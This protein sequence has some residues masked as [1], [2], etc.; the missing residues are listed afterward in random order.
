MKNLVLLGEI[1]RKLNSTSPVSESGDIVSLCEVSP[2]NFE[3]ETSTVVLTENG[4]VTR[5]TEEGDSLWTCNLEEV[6]DVGGGWFD[7]SFIDPELVCL[8]K[9]GAIVTVD[10]TTG[11]AELVGV[12]DQGLE[13][14]AWSPDK[15]ILLMVTSIEDD[16]DE[17]GGESKDPEINSHLMTMNASFEVL[18]EVRIPNY[19]PSSTSSD[20]SISVAWRPDGSLCAVSSVDAEDS[21]RNVRIYKRETLEV[22]AIGRAEDA[23][24]ALVKNLQNASIAWASTGCSQLLASV[25]RKGKK[26]QQVVFF[27]PNGLRHREFVLREQA[28]TVVSTL[29]WNATSDIL[30]V[31]LREEDGSDKIQLWHRCNYHWYL[32]QELRF[33]D[34]RIQRMKFSKENPNELLVILCGLE[35]RMYEVRW[36]PSSVLSFQEKSLAFVVDGSSLN[37]TAFQKALIPPPMFANNCGMEFPIN[38][39]TFC[40]ANQ[41]LGST[42]VQ[43]SNG[44][45]ILLQHTKGTASSYSQMKVLWG[46]KNEIDELSLRSLLI[47][48]AEED[49]LHVVAFQSGACNARKDK[50][51]EIT[52][53]NINT[54]EPRSDIIGSQ[55]LEGR[56]QRA[57]QWSD[58]IDGCIIQLFDGSLFEYE[59]SRPTR[60][61]ASELEPMLELCPWISAIK[62]V[63]PYSDPSH[64]DYNRSR[65]VF[66]LSSKSRLYFNDVMLAD[67]ASSFFLSLNHEFLCYVTTGSRCQ[68]RFL[69]LKEVHAFD[70]LMGPE[71]H[72]VLEGYEP[73][74][75]EQGSRVVAI[76][77]QQPQMILQMPRGNLESIYP[78]ALVLQ[79]LMA[80][81]TAGAYGEAFRMMRKHKVDLNLIVDL[82][83]T[84][85]LESGITS[86][87]KQV[88]N[89][90][91]LNL[92][93]S[94][95]QNYD[96]TQARFPVPTWIQS[97]NE[98]KKG[99]E[100]FDFS[101]KVNSICRKARSV[102][103]DIEKAGEKPSTYYLLPV[104]STFAKENPPKL[105]EALSLIKDDALRLVSV[106]SSTNPLFSENAQS[107]IKYL[108][109]LAEYELLFETALGMYDFDI[110]RAVA[111]N[112]QMDPKVYLPL[113]K[114]LNTLPVFFSRY[115]VDMRLKRFDLALKNLYESHTKKEVVDCF[116]Q[117]QI[118]DGNSFEDC[119]K[120]VNDNK[121]HKLALELFRSDTDKTK[122]ILMALGKSLMEQN[123]PSTALAVYLSTEP[124]DIDG[125]ML[126]ARSARDWR[127]YFSLHESR[128][129]EGSG[130][131]E[132]FRIEKRIQAAREIAD[133]IKAS[134]FASQSVRQANLDA[135]RLLL[136]YGDDLIGA[137]DCLTTAHCWSEA[138]RVAT[139][140]S[141]QD[142]MKKCVDGAIGFAHASLDHF[143]ERVEDFEKTNSKYFEV[144]KLRKQNVYLEGP[145]PAGSIG[146]ETGSLFSLASNASNMSLRS[147]ASTSSSS[148]IGSNV[149]S[150]ISIKT[151]N[152]FSMTGGKDGDRHRS[153]FNKGKKGKKRGKKKKPRKKPGSEEELQSLVGTLKFSCPDAEYS[154]TIT[155]TIQFLVVVQH[156]SLAKELFEAYN[157]MRDSVVKSKLERIEKTAKEKKEAGQLTRSHGVEHD[158]NHLLVDLPVE[159]EVDSLVCAELATNLSDFF[160]FLPN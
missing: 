5:V 124:P 26:T 127:C 153:K 144:L 54:E 29:D 97:K 79:F 99:S 16:D 88:N 151:A 70:M 78:R 40:K 146:G 25:Q 6:E 35:W 133:E 160:Y 95:L 138:Y 80:R 55:V 24:G 72:F 61:M 141:R 64:S 134:T 100:L 48:G 131:E 91:Y 43:M 122:T 142:L 39:M 109:L 129:G 120:L 18:A 10:P 90:D 123:R 59:R 77:P 94:T 33:R 38:S 22:H 13:A 148:S 102:M 15:E 73:R 98:K 30:A 42:L 117:F 110:A 106:K 96:V 119:M 8:S 112:S 159:K 147:T 143:A 107:S 89:I 149:S 12:F 51:V 150:V 132:E 114:R 83:P 17:D 93:I 140:H 52:I 125:A 7:V 23:S 2:Q 14:A 86:F 154:T 137:I 104:L 103:M 57:V 69:P 155:E 126:A 87:V 108:A 116:S 63:T 113:L 9:R 62:D 60:V 21:M 37:L 101:T 76:L 145:E 49:R 32:K 118:S 44:E 68:S 82:H 3:S 1:R 11:T 105:D 27:E 67:S 139:L 28:S 128:N 75:V 135:S 157:S 85:F 71:Q 31:S 20:S 130:D 34:R 115:E 36:D 53:S 41:H 136:D 58:A 84:E 74:N 111:R 4:I 19:V 50:I 152:T 47:V 158:L 65:F 156:F 121:L 66:G 81:I 92:F 56:V 46:D 45:L